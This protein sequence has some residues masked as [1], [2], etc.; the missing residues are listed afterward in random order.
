MFCEVQKAHAFDLLGA[1]SLAH[2][3]Y[4]E[5]IELVYLIFDL[6]LYKI[7]QPITA[8]AVELVE[9]AEEEDLLDTQPLW[10]LGQLIKVQVPD[11]ELV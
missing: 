1:Q 8:Q 7:L 10:R 3:E 4:A 11:K 6:R 9:L 2:V 5:N